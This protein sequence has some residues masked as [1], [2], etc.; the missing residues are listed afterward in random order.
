MIR[1]YA[2]I[3]LQYIRIVSLMRNLAIGA[4]CAYDISCY[5]VCRRYDTKAGYC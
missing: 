5:S 2:P 4:W 1:L 3:K